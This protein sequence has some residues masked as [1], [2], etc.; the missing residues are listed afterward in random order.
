MFVIRLLIITSSLLL[1]NCKDQEKSEAI[2][3]RSQLSKLQNQTVRSI[4][5]NDSQVFQDVHEQDEF[6]K[7][8]QEKIDQCRKLES[9]ILKI[10][11]NCSDTELKESTVLLQQLL[12]I[13]K[14]DHERLKNHIKKALGE[15]SN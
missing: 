15:K 7:C 2:D 6:Y 12:D 3:I 14:K 10:N 1:T 4:L 8:V 5:E 9:E 11:D 13:R